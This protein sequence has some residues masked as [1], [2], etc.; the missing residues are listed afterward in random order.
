MALATRW[1]ALGGAIAAVLLITMASCD[2]G[3]LIDP[4]GDRY[5]EGIAGSWQRVN[6]V[7][8][9]ANEVDRDISRLV[10]S[11]LTAF[12]ATGRV[13]PDLAERWE[14]EDSG[15]TY[16]F[17]LRDDVRWHD[18]EPLRAADVAFTIEQLRDPEYRGDPQ[19]AA[20]WDDVV[21]EIPDDLTVVFRLPSAYAPFLA[22]QTGLGILPEHLL[23]GVSG[24]AMWNAAFNTAPVGTGPYR[25]VTLNRDSAELEAYAEYHGG[26]AAISSIDLRFYPDYPAA[27]RALE[28]GDVNGLLLREVASAGL[29]DEVQ[30]ISGAEVS[31]P[32]RGAYLVLYLNNQHVPFDDELVRTAISLAIDRRAIVEAAFSGTATPSSSPIAPGSWAYQAQFDFGDRD[33]EEARDVLAEAGWE[34]G[35]NGVLT[36]AGTELRFTIRT[37]DDP[38]RRA[39]ASTIAAQLEDV[40]IRASVQSMA[41]SV[42]LRDFLQQRQ[43]DAAV[44][45]WDQG[46]DPDPYSWHSAEV[47]PDGRNIANTQSFLLDSLIGEARTTTDEAVRLDYY[48]QLQ[49]V[50]QSEMPSVI[51]AYPRYLYVQSGSVERDPLG[52]LFTAAER[53]AQI[54]RWGL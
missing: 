24:E 28:D 27:V 20:V 16:R 36:K 29:T 22:R 39:V 45:L 23:A 38:A 47:G 53:F 37:D 54:F 4:A 3:S 43:Y 1:R 32:Q 8:A 11:G 5:V 12:D 21:V 42:L 52:I 48:S 33:L 6:P 17:H 13:V 30:A 7:F 18:G 49:Q 14:V 26:A 19:L 46:A 15:R 10:F 41:F 9:N 35:A 31:E 25:L 51:V 40:G 34:P 50:W 44:V 2:D